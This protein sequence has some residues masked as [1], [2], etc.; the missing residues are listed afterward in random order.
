MIKRVTFIF[1]FILVMSLAPLPPVSAQTG[2]PISPV[3]PLPNGCGPDGIYISGITNPEYGDV[4]LRWNE[5]YP[6]QEAIEFH[7][8]GLEVYWPGVAIRLPQSIPSSDLRIRFAFSAESNAFSYF[9]WR[10][11]T[12]NDSFDMI[13]ESYFYVNDYTNSPVG[14]VHEGWYVLDTVVSAYTGQNGIVTITPT[15]SI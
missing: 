6:C 2:T 10:I 1:L 14:G 5:W 4:Q 15:G 9:R 11:R 8:G 3:L 12:Y 7:K 13:S